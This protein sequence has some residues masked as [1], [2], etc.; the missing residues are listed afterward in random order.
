MK[1]LLS[2]LIA[3]TVVF[4]AGCGDSNNDNVQTP[5]PT[6]TGEE[7]PTVEPRN[8]PQPWRSVN[9]LRYHNN[10]AGGCESTSFLVRDAGGWTAKECDMQSNGNLTAAEQSRLEQLATAA[11]SASKNP[12]ACTEELLLDQDYVAMDGDT[13]RNDRDF[14]PNHNCQI[15]GVAEAD[16]LRAYMAEL[17]EKYAPDLE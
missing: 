16:A 15:G 3:S 12:D 6:S 11:L 17:R 9:L 7:P 2:I 1:N 5:P 10:T 4:F 13:D 8:A 14:R